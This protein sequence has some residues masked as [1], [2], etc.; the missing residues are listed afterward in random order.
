MPACA[1][2]QRLGLQTFYHSDY[3]RSAHQLPWVDTL[4]D[5]S[6]EVLD[7]YDNITR[8]PELLFEM[9]FKPGDIQLLS[10][11]VVLHARSAYRDW[12]EPS[13]KRHLLRLW[14]AL[15]PEMSWQVRLQK[16]LSRAQ[17]LLSFARS[18][19]RMDW[20]WYGHAGDLG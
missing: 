1:Y 10:N 12:D 15:D 16:E 9:E 18:K 20:L 14:V 3:L 19:L 4:D 8:D 7:A 6:A 2:D 5:F 11:H 13:E 17:V